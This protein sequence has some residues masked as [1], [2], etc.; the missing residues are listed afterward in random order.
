MAWQVNGQ[1]IPAVV[2]KVARLQN[3]DTVIVEHAVNEYR[4]RFAGIKFFATGVSIQRGALNL[5]NHAAPPEVGAAFSA[6]RSAR[7]KSSIRSSGSSRPIDKRTVPG[8]MPEAF[9]VSSSTRKC[10]VLAG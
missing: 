3:P 2:G 9:K 1:N 8:P 10:V 6:A 4:S 7:F 5:I